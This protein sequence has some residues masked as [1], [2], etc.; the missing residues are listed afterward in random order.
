MNNNKAMAIELESF[1]FTV[2][3]FN[4]VDYMKSELKRAFEMVE[5]PTNWKNPICDAP[6]P[7]YMRDV[8]EEAVV[9]FAGCRP[10][11]KPFVNAK[12]EANFRLMLVNAPGYY[13]SIGA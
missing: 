11:F 9:F 13:L 7:A 6:I 3:G 2:R 5:D 8:V 4:G 12:G 10:N 1:D